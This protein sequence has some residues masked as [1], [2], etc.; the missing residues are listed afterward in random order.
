[1]KHVLLI[2][3][4]CLVAASSAYAKGGLQ[5]DEGRLSGVKVEG[6]TLSLAY[7][8]TLSFDVPTAPQGHP[9]RQ[10]QSITLDVD[11][12]PI[13]IQRWQVG[14][15]NAGGTFEETATLATQIAHVRHTAKGAIGD[16][17]LT[18]SNTGELVLLEGRGLSLYDLTSILSDTKL[19]S[20]SEQDQSSHSQY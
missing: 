16:P 3:T 10:W 8:G 7:T 17:K 2:G 9:K 6:N 4:V 15:Q 13:R 1:M 19:N 18:L 11:K 12:L 14:M 20:L 5:L